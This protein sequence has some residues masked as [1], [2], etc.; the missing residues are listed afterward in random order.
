MTT[1]LEKRFSMGRAN[2]FS[3]IWKKRGRGVKKKIATLRRINN[4]S[5]CVFRRRRLEVGD[6]GYNYLLEDIFTVK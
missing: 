3:P 4:R 6:G 1:S 2:R 5:E